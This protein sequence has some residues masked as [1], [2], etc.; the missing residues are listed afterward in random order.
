M[1]GYASTVRMPSFAYPPSARPRN[2]WFPYPRAGE[3]VPADKLFQPLLKE[4]ELL[5]LTTIFY[6]VHPPERN[7]SAG[8]GVRVGA[9]SAI[10]AQ[11]YTLNR[12]SSRILLG[13]IGRILMTAFCACLRGV[14]CRNLDRRGQ[15]FPLRFVGKHLLHRRYPRDHHRFGGHS[16]RLSAVAR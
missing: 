16:V 1:V 13:S 10:Y 4:I 15:S 8:V 9:A 3:L 6:L 7:N 12:I 5:E 11:E 2:Y 14:G